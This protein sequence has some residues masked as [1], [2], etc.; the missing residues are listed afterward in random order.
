MSQPPTRAPDG[1]AL[2]ILDLGLFEVH[3][4]GR[5]IGIPAYLIRSGA[6]LLLVDTGFPAA[7]ALDPVAAGRIDGL[8]AF[9]V[10]RAPDATQT[11]A[12]QLAR[13]SVVPAMI[14]HLV[15][16]H[17]HIDH[18]GGLHQFPGATLVLGRA[19]RAA[20]RPLYWGE[21]RP[22]AWPDQ[23]QQLIDAD[24][25]IA[26]G[27]TL[28]RTPGHTPG[29]LSLLVEAPDG[30]AVVLAADAISRPQ[31]LSED[32][33]AGA[34]DPALARASARRLVALAAG[35]GARLIYGHDPAQWPALPKAPERVL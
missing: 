32:R 18:V 9:G 2:T 8:D 6:A 21:R 13:C 12:A 15:L 19:E 7:Y 26:P 23:P 22:L 17:S 33:F 3:E 1:V 16:T 28:L 10:M 34:W 5:V 24:T 27:V 29:H 11:L 35:R 4:D 25:P 30:R 31:E 14:T 20:P